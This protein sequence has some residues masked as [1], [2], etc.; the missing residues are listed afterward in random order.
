MLMMVALIALVKRPTILLKIK[1]M[2]VGGIWGVIATGIWA[3]KS[4]NPD[5]A[6]GLLHG[7]PIQLWIQVKMA[8]IVVAFSFIVGAI[9]LKFVDVVMKLRVSDH[10]ERV[11]LDLTQHREGAYTLIS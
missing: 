7:N 4:V 10:E 2:S 1:E 6:N 9:L 3:T 8:L 5:G 11:G